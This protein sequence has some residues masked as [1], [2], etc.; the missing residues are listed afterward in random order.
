[1]PKKPKKYFSDSQGHY[2]WETHFDRGKQRRSKV[3]VTVIDGQIIEDMDSWLLANAGD[4]DLHALERWDLIET[5]RLEDEISES[6]T[7]M[8]STP[9]TLCLDIED[10]ESA[11]AFA[12]S[13]DS[14]D[15]GVPCHP[16]IDLTT[17][18][19]LNGENDD[20]EEGPVFQVIEQAICNVRVHPWPR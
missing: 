5:R 17:G 15:I 8:E 16:Y 9:L 10:L 6:N 1:M 12:Q 11:F 14:L 13:H 7:N 3:R 19:V 20:E 18:K 4:H 2:V